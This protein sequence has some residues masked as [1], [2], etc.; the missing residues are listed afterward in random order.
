MDYTREELLEAKRQIG[1]T[2]R[3][4]REVIKTLRRKRTRAVI[5]LN[6]PWQGAG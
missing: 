5:S 3:K 1:S 6:L 4:L 2:L